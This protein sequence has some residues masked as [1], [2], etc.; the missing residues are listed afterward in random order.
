[1]TGPRVPIETRRVTI[2]IPTYSRGRGLPRLWPD[3]YS[4][5]VEIRGGY[6]NIS[7]DSQGLRG[8]ATQL[9][10]LAEEGVPDGYADDLDD[11]G[12]LDVGSSQ[13]TIVRR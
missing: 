8:L 3:R 7:G 10:A 1:L 12:E 2:E 9:L 5:K 6:V 13:L 4:L 11:L